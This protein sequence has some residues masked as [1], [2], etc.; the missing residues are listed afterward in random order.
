M[1]GM[2]ATLQSK[3]SEPLRNKGELFL[4]L[5][6]NQKISYSPVRAAADFQ[7]EARSR[8]G[9]KSVILELQAFET[10]SGGVLAA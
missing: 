8:M 6:Q 7:V 2:D 4:P 1:Q 5:P 9:R 10:G 3:E